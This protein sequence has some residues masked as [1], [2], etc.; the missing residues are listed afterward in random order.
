MSNA[1][2]S[3]TADSNTVEA[4]RMMKDILTTATALLIAPLEMVR[5]KSTTES[6]FF[7]VAKAEASNIVMVTVFT[8]PAVPTGEPPINIS[9]M[10]TIAVAL[11]RFC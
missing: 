8:P 5:S 4:N 9:I 6:L 10:E 1:L 2:A 7:M 3:V 11:V